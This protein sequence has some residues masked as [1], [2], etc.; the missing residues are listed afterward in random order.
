ME[1]YVN[2]RDLWDARLCEA[3]ANI[4]QIR[5]LLK[6]GLVN[7]VNG[8]NK[9]LNDAPKTLLQFI[10]GK[11]IKPM[12]ESFEQAV[13]YSASVFYRLD[14]Y[15]HEL[16]IREISEHS[17]SEMRAFS[18][19]LAALRST[20]G[21]TFVMRDDEVC[22]INSYADPGVIRRCVDRFNYD[23]IY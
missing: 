10:F 14:R 21:F 1:L 5:G 12:V 2:D 22:D 11:K 8:K 6:I 19:M 3:I 15:I 4:E 7:H 9:R 13:T 18:N 16:Y 20:T 23:V 17:E